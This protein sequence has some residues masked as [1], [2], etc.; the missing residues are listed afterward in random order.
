MEPIKS[1][2]EHRRVLLEIDAL[3]DAE[4][5]THEGEQLDRLVSRAVEWEEC[6]TSS[7]HPTKL[8]LSISRKSSGGNLWIWQ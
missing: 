1:D 7:K 3:M 4:A 8:T 6:I 5:G 2:E